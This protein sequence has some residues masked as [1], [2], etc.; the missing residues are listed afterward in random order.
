MTVSLVTCRN[1]GEDFAA[2][3]G[4]CPG[5]GHPRVEPAGYPVGASC[6]SCGAQRLTLDGGRELELG[7]PC[8]SCGSLSV[9]VP[10]KPGEWVG[11]VLNSG[12]AT[13]VG[14]PPPELSTPT[15]EGEV[16]A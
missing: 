8:V 10:R 13:A 12:G 1:C 7:E 6:D 16:A 4:A 5:C 11:E 3:D 15:A 2:D 9:R 14:S